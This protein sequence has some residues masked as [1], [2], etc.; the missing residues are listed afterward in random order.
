MVAIK[1]HAL[2]RKKGT[3]VDLTSWELLKTH[4]WGL[5]NFEIPE[6]VKHA[7]FWLDLAVVNRDRS[8]F[9]MMYMDESLSL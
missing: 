6:P 5:W 4:I 7:S 1:T 8:L 3:I 9:W 2:N